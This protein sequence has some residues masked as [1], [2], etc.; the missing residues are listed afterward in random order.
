MCLGVLLVGLN[1]SENDYLTETLMNKIFNGTVRND[2]NITNYI[3]ARDKVFSLIQVN[4]AFQTGP[5]VVLFH[6]NLKNVRRGLNLNNKTLHLRSIGKYL[7][8]NT[9]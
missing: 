5:I 2:Y 4:P 9:R 3:F 7:H 1:G 8:N 6:E